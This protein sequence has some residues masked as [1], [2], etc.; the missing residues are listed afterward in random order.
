VLQQHGKPG[1]SRLANFFELGGVAV[2]WVHLD[3]A[4]FAK[5]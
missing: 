4:A 2:W 3:G 1:I 5:T